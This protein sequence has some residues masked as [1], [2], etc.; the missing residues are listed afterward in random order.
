MA[1]YLSGGRINLVSFR[2]EA[3]KELLNCLDKCPG[4]KVRCVLFYFGI[5]TNSRFA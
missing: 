5:G 1:A 3:R 4:S 2:D